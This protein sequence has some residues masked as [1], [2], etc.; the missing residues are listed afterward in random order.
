ML[1]VTSYMVLSHERKLRKL[2]SKN[3]QKKLKTTLFIDEKVYKMMQ[4][5]NSYNDVI[6]V[7]NK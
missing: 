6:Y 5:Y 2:L 7:P 1:L 4:L 3:T